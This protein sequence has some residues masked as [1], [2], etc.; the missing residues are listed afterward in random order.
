MRHP[1]GADTADRLHAMML[2]RALKPPKNR[3]SRLCGAA[4]RGSQRIISDKLED[5][6]AQACAQR[7][8]EFAARR[9][10]HLDSLAA[11]CLRFGLPNAAERLSR[12]AWEIR[13]E[14]L[15]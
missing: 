13:A 14:V 10:T 11:N 12:T 4:S 8:C 7:A 5:R 6:A 9:V 15:I 3:E 2:H 1:S